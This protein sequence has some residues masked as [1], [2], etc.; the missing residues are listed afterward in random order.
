MVRFGILGA[1]RIGPT[2]LIN[3]A[4]SNLGASVVG[5]AASSP[6]KAEAYAADHRIA[7]A[8]G[9]Y[10]ALLAS[11]EIDAV[12]NALPPAYH[13]RWSIAA[14]EAGKHVLCEKPFA[15]DAGEARRMVDAARASGCQLLEAFH[16]RCH[17]F[18]RRGLEL[19]RSGTI[20]AVRHIEAVFNARLP[21]RPGELR[22]IPALGGGALMD[23]GCY[24]VNALGA[25]AGDGWRVTRASCE[26][27]P[28]GVDLT[29]AAELELDSGITAAVYCSMARPTPGSHDTHIRIEGE[30]G[31]LLLENFV[32]PHLGNRIRIE[33]GADIV[34]ESAPERMSYDY[35]LDH[36]LA[37]VAGQEAPL[38]G[39]EDAIATMALIDAIYAA[40]G[41]ERP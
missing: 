34:E 25:L 27:G 4:A 1:A 22:Y 23:L 32:A 13:A 17:P 16:Y 5:V 38:T 28:S 14:L 36:F 29:T 3:R 31:R 19:L 41:F 20:G 26:R 2:A 8:F 12:Y 10:E 21:D 15:M 37:V 30:D 35:Q 33:A 39:G 6:A 11:P 40:A 7:R 9:G 24:P 18:F